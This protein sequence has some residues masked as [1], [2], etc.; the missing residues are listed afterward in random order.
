[1]LFNEN[2]KYVDEYGRGLGHTYWKDSIAQYP[3]PY[4]I[5][6]L[7][8]YKK[9]I[10]SCGTPDLTTVGTNES[11]KK[12]ADFSIYPNPV[13]STFTLQ[14]TSPYDNLQCSLHNLLG[15]SIMTMELNGET[16]KIDISH[17]KRGIYYLDIKTDNKT[18]TIKLIKE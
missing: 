16:N 15:Q 17:L 7:F 4:F 11:L 13:K 6:E 14:D 1:M 12:F 8:Y 18:S 10:Y 9:G 5:T 2:D 3:T